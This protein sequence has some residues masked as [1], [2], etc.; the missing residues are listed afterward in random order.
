MCLTS[1]QKSLDRTP[2]QHVRKCVPAVQ[3]CGLNVVAAIHPWRACSARYPFR[4]FG[5]LFLITGGVS[6]VV[7]LSLPTRQ[8]RHDEAIGGYH[9]ALGL[10][11]DDPFAAEML[12][13]A[14]D[15]RSL[16]H[17]SQA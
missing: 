1:S 3:A 10:K 7:A 12:N 9:K 6:P 14:L 2:T 15:V 17:L 16:S 4:G 5:A 13:K 8:G 11:P